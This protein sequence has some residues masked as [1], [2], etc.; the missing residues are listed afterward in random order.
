VI[1]RVNWRLFFSVLATAS[2]LAF[3]LHVWPHI[4]FSLLLVLIV[5]SLRINGIIAA[6]E[7]RQPGGFLGPSPDDDKDRRQ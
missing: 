2:L 6:W 4:S 3:G 1:G 7:D 5:A